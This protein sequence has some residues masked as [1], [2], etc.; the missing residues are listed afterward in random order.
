MPSTQVKPFWEAIVMNIH[1]VVKRSSLPFFILIFVLSLPFWVLGAMS[2]SPEG[3]TNIPL[4]II[5]GYTPLV[6]AAILVWRKE[7]LSGVGRLLSRVLDY[8]RITNKIWYI[9]AIGFLPALLLLSYGLMLLLGLPLSSSSFPLGLIPVLLVAFFIEAIGEEVGWMGYAIDPLQDR[10]HALGASL[11]VGAA[12]GL[13]HVVPLIEAHRSLTWIAGWF[14][15]PLAG[16]IILVWLYNN[17]GR[18]VFA[19]ILA[20]ALFNAASSL[21]PTYDAS[22]VQF[23]TGGVLVVAAGII[24]FL[25]GPKTFTRFRSPNPGGSTLGEKR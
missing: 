18:S 13:W 7:G 17:T 6:A 23:L 15:G 12:W 11:I 4:S 24:T 21:L 22:V 3:P 19:V 20:H 14:L 2:A 10:W 9:P 16:R 8:K 5:G 25:W 1:A